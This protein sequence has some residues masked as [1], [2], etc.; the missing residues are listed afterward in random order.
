MS[1]GGKRFLYRSPGQIAGPPP[2]SP[3][4]LVPFTRIGEINGS[5]GRVQGPRHPFGSRGLRATKTVVEKLPGADKVLGRGAAGTKTPPPEYVVV[6]DLPDAV[7]KCYLSVLVWLVHVGDNHIDE[8]EL[9]EIQILATQLRCNAEVRQ[10]VRSRLE[11][12]QNLDVEAQIALM[13]ERV[14]SGKS[15]GT[16][17]VRCSL[18]KDAIRVWRANSDGSAREQPPYAGWPS[19][20]SWMTRRSPSLRRPASRTQESSPAKSRTP[21]SRRWRR[22]WPRMRQASAFRWPPST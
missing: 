3:C 19:C 5:S 10:A 1:Q 12:P 7:K 20:W 11:D 15:D 6:E 2:A 13:L 4:S 16:L 22:R 9:C 18:M 17:A 8:R 21:R 14:R